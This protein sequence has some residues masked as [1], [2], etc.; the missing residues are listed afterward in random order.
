MPLGTTLSIEIDVP[1][2][3]GF[4]DTNVL[5]A[6]FDRRD[7]RH[8]DAT[9]FLDE[10]AEHEWYVSFPVIGEASNLLERRTNSSHVRKMMEWINTP[11]RISILPVG[12]FASE[13]HE[14]LSL[15]TS[16]MFRYAIDY[17]DAHLMELAGVLT[18]RFTLKPSLPIATFDTKDF[19]RCGKA[20]SGYSVF[21]VQ[22]HELIEF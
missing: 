6:Y 14:L 19:L 11:G 4:V 13:R 9:L 7:G 5:V 2:N 3:I 1:R 10:D 18:D 12:H 16:W 22:D 20:G 21:D 15:Q 8:E 17:V